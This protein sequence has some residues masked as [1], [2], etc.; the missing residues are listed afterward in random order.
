MR[1]APIRVF[2]TLAPVFARAREVARTSQW[3][4]N[5][6]YFDISA[7]VAAIAVV[8]DHG[9]HGDHDDHTMLMQR[10]GSC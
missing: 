1:T 2:V 9:D 4:F 3:L 8:A 6:R 7:A 5:M 10:H